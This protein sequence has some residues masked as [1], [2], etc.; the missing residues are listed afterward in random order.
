[1]QFPDS[2]AE[3][4]AQLQQDIQQAVL[5]GIRSYFR[6]CQQRVPDFVT[7]HFSYPAALKTNRVAFGLDIL[8]APVN[9]FWAPLY[10]LVSLIRFFVGRS[11]RLSWLHRLLG[12][13]PAGF[14]TQVQTHISDLVLRDLLR[15]HQTSES[16]SWYIAEALR[17]LYQQQGVGDP[18]IAQFH[19]QA[20][21][22]IEDALAQ[23]RVT[24]TASADITNTLSCT[25]LG[26]FA[27]QKFTPGGIGIGL[28]LASMVSTQ[29]ASRDFFLG[30]TLGSAYYGVF[31]PS[32]SIGIT[33][34]TIAGVL[35]LLSAGAA[36]SG[37]ISDPVQAATG[38]HRYRLTKMLKHMEQDMLKQSSSSF[39]PKDQYIA[40][41]MECF[42]LLRAGL[43]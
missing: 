15:H 28:M 20:E 16:L 30:E 11:P 14:T 31:P 21:P 36:L 26:A 39:R 17:E 35:A 5:K 18:D 3:G 24:R 42:D 12:R 8:R 37:V 23:Y 34:A 7:A 22:I 40:R 41:I 19:R 29:L 9:L 13:F 33:L 2:Q 27:F 6:R 32:P 10:A 38:L 1:M 25:V 43:L 4:D